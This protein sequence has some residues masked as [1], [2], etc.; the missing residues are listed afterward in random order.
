MANHK[1]YMNSCVKR[2]DN[3]ILLD[4]FIF[5]ISNNVTMLDILFTNS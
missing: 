1:G 3:V 5:K 2:V 4:I